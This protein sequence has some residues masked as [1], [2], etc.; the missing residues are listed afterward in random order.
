MGAV[1]ADMFNEISGAPVEPSR[2]RAIG[3]RSTAVI[4]AVDY[5]VD[6]FGLTSDRRVE[7]LQLMSNSI[8]SGRVYSFPETPQLGNC[9]R[10]LSGLFRELQ[11]APFGHRFQDAFVQLAD[12]AIEQ[13]RV[14][15][16]FDLAV[17]LGGATAGVIGI[18][19]YCWAD[20]DERFLRASRAIG[21]YIQ[22]FDDLLDRERDQRHG[23]HTFA[24]Q[25]EDVTT[26]TSEAVSVAQTLID[27]AYN[28]LQPRERWV[29]DCFLA[30]ATLG[31]KQLRAYRDLAPLPKVSRRDDR[32]D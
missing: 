30:G 18:V 6:D 19:P 17:R 7:I 3:A 25:S 5:L 26:L 16:S 10:M 23:I 9:S 1:I 22:I 21:S 31:S 14:P 13:I 29:I 11:K 15:G 20:L 32:M 4:W 24:T 8:N 28:E 2:A 27:Q 12:V